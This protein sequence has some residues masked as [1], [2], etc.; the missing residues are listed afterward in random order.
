MKHGFRGASLIANGISTL[1]L[2]LESIVPAHSGVLFN[3]LCDERLYEF[4]DDS[5]P[6][7]SDVLHSRYERLAT[8]VSSDGREIW[9][10]WAVRLRHNDHYIGVVQATIDQDR[11]AIIAYVL[12]REFWGHGY[13]RESVSAMLKQLQNAHGV[14]RFR[15]CVDPRNKRSIAL[16]QSLRFIQSAC[17]V[18]SAVLHGTV[19]DE[20]EYVREEPFARV[21]AESVIDKNQRLPPE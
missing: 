1:R 17:N 20:S 10:N 7:S 2:V 16:L 14:T 9:L 18:G 12:F 6:V 15:A 13:G 3:G 21:G 19:A 5:P 11:S 4:I 8:G